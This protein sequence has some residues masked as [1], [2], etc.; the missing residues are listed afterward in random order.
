MTFEHIWQLVD[1]FNRRFP[2][3]NTPFQ[4]ISRLA[5]E[6]GELAEQVNM[7]EIHGIASRF[8]FAKEIEDVIR[9]T[10]T[11]ARYYHLN[12]DLT[13]EQLYAQA[14][15]VQ[16]QMPS[17]SP[18]YSISAL[19]EWLGKTT[20]HVNHAE[21]MGRKKEKYGEL[22]H[23]KFAQTLTSLLLTVAVITCFYHLE[24]DVQCAFEHSY[25]R[26][27]ELGFISPPV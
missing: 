9:A 23:V 19:C 21:G 18:F 10:L 11:I 3:G 1:A 2:D 26:M 15:N 25:Q 17:S 12:V 7:A 24:D 6:C 5:E 22:D 13:F 16:E 27:A 8:H 20:K 14:T 4:L